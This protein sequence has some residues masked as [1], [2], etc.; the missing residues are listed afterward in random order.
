MFCELMDDEG[1]A[2]K[3]NIAEETF[4]Y[5]PALTGTNARRERVNVL[6]PCWDIIKGKEKSV[7]NEYVYYVNAKA[8]TSALSSYAC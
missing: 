8:R 2:G 4:H 6:E 1:Q 5:D 7:C 3:Q